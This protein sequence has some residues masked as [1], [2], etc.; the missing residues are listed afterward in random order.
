M[1]THQ[2]VSECKPA[3]KMAIKPERIRLQVYTPGMQK[4]LFEFLHKC[5]PESGRTFE[6]F[7][8]HQAVTTVSD[9]FLAFWCLTDG[10]EVV[11]CCAVKTLAPDTCELK[12]MY[13][14]NSYQGLGLGR[15]LLTHAIQYGK[16]QGYQKMLLD[17]TSE[18]L[19]AISLYRKNGFYEIPRYNQNRYADVFMQKDLC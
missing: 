15:K 11:G 19:S 5:M 12:M 4:Y 13:L 17:T 14:Y 6:P 7:G 18:S 9:T 10:D 8:R 1:E 16:A 2:N 3:V